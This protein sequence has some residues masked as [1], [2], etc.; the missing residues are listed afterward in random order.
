VRSGEAKKN[1]ILVVITQPAN[2]PEHVL[3]GDVRSF[4]I[5]NN[6]FQRNLVEQR[7]YLFARAQE[8]GVEG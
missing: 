4:K 7:Q 2:Q 1:Q 8:R 3:I 6:G 5:Q